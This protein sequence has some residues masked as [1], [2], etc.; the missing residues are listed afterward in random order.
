MGLGIIVLF[1]KCFWIFQ[2]LFHRCSI[3]LADILCYFLLMDFVF[4]LECYIPL[5]S[6]SILDSLDVNWIAACMAHQC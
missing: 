2:H 1:S 3:V 4:V 6:C 5:F